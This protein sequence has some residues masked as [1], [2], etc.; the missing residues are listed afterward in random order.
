MHDAAAGKGGFERVERRGELGDAPRDLVL[1]RHVDVVFGKVDAGFEQGDEFD[2]RLFDGRHAVAERAAHLA[3]GL[4]RLGEG[5][6]VDEVANRF[7]LREVEP[8]GEECALGKFAGLGQ[9]RA[10]LEGAAQQQLQHHG[11]AVRCDL[12]QIFGGIGARSA[13]ST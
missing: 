12:N 9:A 10:Q 13:R 11:R 1:R 4:A 5:L 8:A 2:E 3:G 6:R 7:S